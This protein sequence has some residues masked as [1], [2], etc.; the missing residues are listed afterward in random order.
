MRTI[1][2]PRSI[3]TEERR[4]RPLRDS[5]NRFVPL[6]EVFT[7][8]LWEL[9]ED[10]QHAVAEMCDVEPAGVFVEALI[11]KSRRGPRQRNIAQGA[12]QK[13]ARWKRYGRIRRGRSSR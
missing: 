9:G 12:K 13:L 4:D 3:S 8:V 6:A 7:L 10:R 11:V 2:K 5:P 1:T